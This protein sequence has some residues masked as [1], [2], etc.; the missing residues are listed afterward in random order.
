MSSFYAPTE[1][2]FNEYACDVVEKYLLKDGDLSCFFVVD[3]SIEN[4]KYYKSFESHFNFCMSGK[5][6]VG[7]NEPT[8]AD[9]DDIKRPAFGRN[10]IAVG[11]GST[12]DFAKALSVVW[13]SPFDEHK[14]AADFQGFDLVKHE[15]IPVVAVPTTFSGSE[16]TGTAVLI[17]EE[18]KLKLGINSRNII[19]KIAVLDSFFLEE[20]PNEVLFSSCID[21]FV[22]A[23]ESFYSKRATTISRS[24]SLDASKSLCNGYT[25]YFMNDSKK[26][27]GLIEM[28]RG[29]AL[30]GCAI[31]NAGTGVTHAISYALGTFFKVPHSKAVAIIF[32][33]VFS[34][35]SKHD[36]FKGSGYEY[37]WNFSECLE[38]ELAIHKHPT[39]KDYGITYRDIDKLVDASF[40]LKSAMENSLIAFDKKGVE[41]IFLEA[42]W[43]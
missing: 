30:A 15:C 3:K 18:K 33:H 2:I 10:I 27:L 23:F 39:L 37:Y 13:S 12:I 31:M 20:C 41:K 19:P 29:S 7:Y 35:Y 4:T 42:I 38:H 22:H 14:K 24:Y 34:K 9:I 40:E 17:N 8:T 26:H 6:L 5:I 36:E 11:G 1:I 43:K 21:A 25:D 16:C 28:Q 32:P